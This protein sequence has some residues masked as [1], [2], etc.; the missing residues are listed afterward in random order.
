MREAIL[1][2]VKLLQGAAVEAHRTN[3]IVWASRTA[4]GG[5]IKPPV[6]P[7]LLKEYSS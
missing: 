2:Y 1:A 6:L 5:D 4:F 7:P 3:M